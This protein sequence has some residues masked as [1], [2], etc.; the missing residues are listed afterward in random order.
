MRKVRTVQVVRRC[1]ES[2][3]IVLAC[4][5]PAFAQ[6]LPLN[7][8]PT[9]YDLS[10]TPD[11]QKATFAGSERIEVTTTSRFGN[12]RRQV[13]PTLARQ[14]FHRSLKGLSA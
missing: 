2:A 1:I 11:L 4:A 9:H 13:L 14:P 7:V 8:T 6:R 10:V 12:R 5:I 3:A